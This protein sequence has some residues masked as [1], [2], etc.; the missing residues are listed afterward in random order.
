MKVKT[1]LCFRCEHRAE[2]LED[3]IRLRSQCGDTGKAVCSCYAYKPVKPLIIKRDRTDKVRPVIFGG[4]VLS[5]RVETVGIKE[6]GLYVKKCKEGYLVYWKPNEKST[7]FKM[8]KRKPK[9]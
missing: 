8:K 1:G 5:S 3:K 6:L 9:P 2:F 7:H 4:S